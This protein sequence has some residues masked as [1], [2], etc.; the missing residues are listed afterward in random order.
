MSARV[1]DRVSCP[2][3]RSLSRTL[4]ALCLGLGALLTGGL[5][6]PAQAQTA[7]RLA[8]DRRFDGTNAVFLVALDKGY[9]KAE[10]LDVSVEPGTGSR[11]ALQRLASGQADVAL[12]DVNALI[13]FRDELPDAGL[14]AVAMVQDRPDYAIVGRKSRGVTDDPKSLEGKHVG[15]PAADAS[16]AAWPLFKLLHKLDDSAMRFENVGFP[17]RE[18]MLASGELDAVFGFAATSFVNL[19]ARGVPPEDISV[20][21]MADQGVALYGNAV[22]ATPKLMAENPEALRGF[23][24]A[25]IRSLREV[26]RHPAEAMASVLSRNDTA[27]A[28]IER[29]R[30]QMNLATNM[31]TPWVKAHGFGGIDRARWERAVEQLALIYKFKDKAKASDAFA[32]TLLPPTPDRIF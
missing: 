18:P 21:L 13:R 7:L 10:G 27:D 1:P 12:G 14:K 19:K 31:L 9:F 28:A 2:F 6:G 30:L 8:L 25:L 29:E 22:I 16:F 20:M 5:A 24:R 32:D 3:R 23:V 26:A 11:E 15:A 17:V 4:L